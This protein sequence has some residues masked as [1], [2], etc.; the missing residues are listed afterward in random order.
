MGISSDTRSPNL[1]AV[2]ELFTLDASAIGGPIYRFSNQKNQLGNDIVWGGVTFTA[3]PI[4]AFGFDKAVNGSIPRP[5]IKISNVL[6][7]LIGVLD[8][9]DDL[10]GAK[11]TRQ[12][13]LAKYLDAVNFPGNTNA[14]ASTTEKFE[15]EIFFVQR[16]VSQNRLEIEFEL[17]SSFDLEGLKLPRRLI[18]PVCP[19]TYR[20][21]ECTYSGGAVAKQD[22]TA[23]A[24]L[25]EDKC[26][27]RI[28]SCK[29][30]FGANATLP[31]GGFP[32]A[33]IVR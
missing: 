16:K 5:T 29:L 18:I 17:S 15:D 9:Y 33:G 30:R 12:R 6:G 13:T 20:G 11:V 27:K 1:G 22:D 31:H 7:F 10:V 2:V 32:T 14:N 8:T 24:I 28:S 23:T 26:G 19:W 3:I 4:K 25:A 21:A